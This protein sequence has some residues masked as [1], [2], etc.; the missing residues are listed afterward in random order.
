LILGGSQGARAINRLMVEAVG[1]LAEK[2]RIQIIHQTGIHDAEWV[3]AGY[4]AAAVAARVEPFISDMAAVYGA[5]D[6]IVSRAGAT[7]LAEI[8]VF[9][10]PAILIPYPYAADDHQRYNA[11]YLVEQGAALMADEAELDGTKLAAMLAELLADAA[12]RR[13]MAERAKA[14]G[15]PEATETILNECLALAGA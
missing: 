6:L 10:R 7:T 4:N 15:R 11:R 1:Q 13:Q 3:Q 5:A 14:L 9:G 12:K 8:T 2:N